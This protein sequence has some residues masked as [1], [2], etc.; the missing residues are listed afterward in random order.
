[1]RTILLVAVL[2]IG[3]MVSMTGFA[4]SMRCGNKLVRS[5]SSSAE[6]LLVCGEPILREVSS[7]EKDKT[8][9]TSVTGSTSS[10]VQ[11]RVE[12]WTYNQ[13]SGKLLKILTFRDGELVSIETG[14]RM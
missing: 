11:I 5:G 13:G 12:K 9:E 10:S 4:D 8:E 6:V 7:L 2:A 14:T 1:M 3:P